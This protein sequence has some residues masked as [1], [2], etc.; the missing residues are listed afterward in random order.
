MNV[1]LIGV[2][3]M[4]MS[5]AKRILRAN[6]RLIVYNRTREK[7]KAL[8]HLGIGVARSPNEVITSSDCIILIVSD[9]QAIQD[10]L[11]VQSSLTSL[12]GRTVIQMGTISPHESIALEKEVAG[13][14]G[15]YL[16]APVLGSIPETEKGELIVMVGATPE[17]FRLWSEFLKCFGPEPLL[18]GPVGQAAALKLA[19][20][21]LI[22]SLTAAF[23][24]SLA[25]VKEKGI[26]VDLFMRVLRE[27]VLYAPT[28]DKKIRRMIDRDYARPNFPSK[29]LFKDI[30]L[31]LNEAKSMSL[32]TSSLEGVLHLVERTLISGWGESD[33]SAMFDTIRHRPSF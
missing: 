33:Y 19:L 4:G 14:G 18:I 22:A 13:L 29:H 10:V 23:G 27:S 7:A 30:K 3:L 26:D 17:H 31:F 28:F 32:E 11:F 5:M 16:E 20:N 21:Q 15:D 2:G 9:A 6:H 24:L 1:G 8:A 25:F 12:S